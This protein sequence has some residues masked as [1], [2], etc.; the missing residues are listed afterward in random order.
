MKV[1]EQRYNRKDID[2]KQL[3]DYCEQYGEVYN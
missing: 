1:M 3:Y 2:L